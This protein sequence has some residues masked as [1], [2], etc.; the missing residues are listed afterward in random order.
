M[1]DLRGNKDQLFFYYLILFYDLKQ[2]KHK[3]YAN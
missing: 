2:F 1:A 3:I